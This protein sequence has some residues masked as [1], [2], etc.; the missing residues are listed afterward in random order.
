ML[1]VDHIVSYVFGLFSAG[2]L[3]YLV[4]THRSEI[5]GAF[6]GKNEKLDIHELAALYWFFMFAV[7]F[8]S[9]LFLGK[10]AGPHIWYSLDT[11]FLI[12][13]GGDKIGKIKGDKKD[14]KK[15]V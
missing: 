5:W 6:R 1:S 11:I 10:T 12:I 15:E 2:Y 8:F 14:E 3:F 9:E 7:L 13:I 4:R